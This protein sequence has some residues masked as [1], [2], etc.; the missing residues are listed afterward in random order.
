MKKVLVIAPHPDDEV[1]G[2]GGTIM[3][4]VKN[5]DQVYLCIV[6]R[7]YTPDWS[8]DFIKE[9]EK[10]IEKSKAILGVN[11]VFFLN[12]PTA[13]LDTIS[14]KEINKSIEEVVI[15]TGAEVVLIPHQGDLHADH[16]IVFLSSLVATRPNQKNSV[17]KVLS[18]EVLSETNWGDAIFPFVPNTYVNISDTIKGKVEA[19]EAYKSEI[20]K[21]P[22]PRSSEMITCLAQKRGGEVGLK[23]AEAFL[24]I[25]EIN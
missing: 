13:K 11:K 21:Y 6:T 24:L 4:H 9:R 12:F 23:F 20:K 22:H 5:G 10:E 16:R 1:L 15:E 2:C 18:Y 7:A 14:Q 3:N 17:K 8:E 25:R 19:M